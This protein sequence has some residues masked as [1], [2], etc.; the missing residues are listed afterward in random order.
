[1]AAGGGIGQ[2]NA[3]AAPLSAR[4][5]HVYAL[6]TFLSVLALICSGGLVTSKGAGLAV[7]DWPNSY[8]YNMFAFPISRWVGGV[9]YEHSHRLIASG[10][11]MLTLGLAGLLWRFDRR[12][13][14][15]WLGIGAVAAVILQGVLGGLRVVWLKD[16]IGIFHACLAQAFLV[17]IGLIAL[18]TSKWWQRVGRMTP[19]RFAAENAGALRTALIVLAG[20][21]YLQLALGATMRHAH[22]GLSIR[23]F[24]T[25]YGKIWPPTDAA[26]IARINHERT[27]SLGLPPTSAAQIVLQMMHRLGAALIALGVCAVAWMTWQRRGE[28]PV[29]LGRLGLLGP[30]LIAGQLTLGIYTI[31]TNKAADVATAHVA[32]GAISLVW[33]ALLAIALARWATGGGQPETLR[34]ALAR[35]PMEAL[36]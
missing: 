20:L 32:V 35:Q 28:L 25:A 27:E 2:V 4:L 19:P 16:E 17:L 14:M 22:A 8:G 5:L 13:W 18:A 33:A 15:R 23:D 24:P 12:R 9:F 21:I 34:T 3:D 10:V 36:A 1:M 7:P 26:T 11:G 29:S 31:W 30:G 6:F